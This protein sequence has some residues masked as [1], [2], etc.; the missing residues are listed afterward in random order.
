MGT[1]NYQNRISKLR[2][3]RQG[4]ESSLLKSMAMDSAD[5]LE[6]YEKRARATSLQYALGAMQEV[7]A[8]YTRISHEQ[9]NRVSSQIVSALSQP[10]DIRLQGSLPLN[11]H[12]KK[13]SDVDILVLPSTYFLYSPYGSKA[14]SYT[15]SNRN[16]IEVVKELRGDCYGVLQTAFPAAKIDNSGSKC[17]TVS[18]G[19]LSRSID[20]VPALWHDSATF[21]DS[22]NEKDRGVEILD[23]DAHLLNENFPFL[24]Q[25]R[26]N[27]KDLVTQSGTKKAIRL[28]KTLKYDAEPEIKITSFDIASLIWNT[29]NEYLDYPS[30]LETALIVSIQKHLNSLCNDRAYAETLDVADGTRKII[31]SES[32]FLSLNA[33]NRELKELIEA[34]ALEVKPNLSWSFEAAQKALMEE[35]IW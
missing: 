7:D 23:L 26:I 25:S 29:P 8:K 20:V 21:Q 13:H 5:N 19:S 15:P 14:A 16:R 22:Q 34:I 2:E 3:R 17:I 12:L 9:G 1:T 28:L 4:S 11:I 18:G 6:A 31:R 24:Y 33:L 32:D 10:V 35:T 27:H 30:Y